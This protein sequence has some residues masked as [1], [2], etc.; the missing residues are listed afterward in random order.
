MS[1]LLIVLSLFLGTVQ[2]LPVQITYT[3]PMGYGETWVHYG[4]GAAAVSGDCQP[5]LGPAYIQ[6][7]TLWNGKVYRTLFSGDCALNVRVQ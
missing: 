5:H 6:E 1:T 7:V 4:A 3:E 2:G